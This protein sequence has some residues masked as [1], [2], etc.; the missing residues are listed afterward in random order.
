MNTLCQINPVNA[1]ARIARRMLAC[2]YRNFVQGES[3]FRWS[4]P[5]EQ[6]LL[7]GY[8]A[9]RTPPPEVGGGAYSPGDRT[10]V[11]CTRTAHWLYSVNKYATHPGVE[12]RANLKSISHRCHLFEVAFVWELTKETIQLPLG[13]I[14]GGSHGTAIPESVA[15]LI[16][17]LEPGRRFLPIAMLRHSWLVRIPSWPARGRNR[18]VLFPA[19]GGGIHVARPHHFDARILPGGW[20]FRSY[21]RT[22]SV[23][24]SGPSSSK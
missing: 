18:K 24:K 4:N 7:Q 8:L 20:G 23:I 9:H 22:G 11:P 16:G 19:H 10:S 6:S 17:A 21:F 14:Q 5:R 12:L 2:L 3:C 1:A 13:C 15:A